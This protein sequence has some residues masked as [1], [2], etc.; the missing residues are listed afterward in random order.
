[1]KSSTPNPR[2][3]VV[4]DEEINR[5]LMEAVLTAEG[6]TVEHAA[7]GEECLE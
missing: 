7:T 3:L 1:M 2:I 5:A 4:D 6:Y